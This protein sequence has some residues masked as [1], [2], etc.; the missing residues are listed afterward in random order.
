MKIFILNFKD[1]YGELFTVQGNNRKE[2][3]KA[4]WDLIKDK[5]KLADITM[6]IDEEKKICKI[7]N[8]LY[9]GEFYRLIV[10]EDNLPPSEY[11]NEFIYSDY[12]PEKIT[13]V[14]FGNGMFFSTFKS[15]TFIYGK[16]VKDNEYVITSFMNPETEQPPESYEEFVGCCFYLMQHLGSLLL[17]TS[18]DSD[19]NSQF[20][21]AI[22]IEDTSG[23]PLDLK[24]K[25]KCSDTVCTLEE[26]IR[27]KE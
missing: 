18:F 26:I 23:A 10:Y 3:E 11:T 13:H 8:K 2:V 15:L 1:V 24:T 19:F 25:V 22:E 5:P 6:K 4:W 14:Q 12:I 21:T 17:V 7:Y 20:I 9:D 27:E 16:R